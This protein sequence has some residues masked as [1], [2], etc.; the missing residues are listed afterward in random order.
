MGLPVSSALSDTEEIVDYFYADYGLNRFFLDK[1]F[2][3]LI[4][5]QSKV[6]R[7]EILLTLNQIFVA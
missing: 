3:I 1:I 4:T 5:V 2:S 6:L 7:S